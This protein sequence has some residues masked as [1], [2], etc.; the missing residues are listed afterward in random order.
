MVSSAVPQG[1]QRLVA[2]YLQQALPQRH[3]AVAAALSLMLME[4]VFQMLGHASDGGRV[5]APVAAMRA[6]LEADP[7]LD[8]V[9]ESAQDQ[10]SKRDLAAPH[11]ELMS[12]LD[13]V[14]P[15]QSHT[16]V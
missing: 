16:A 13:S 11:L 9:V 6:D 10:A 7:V 4:A 14:A 15:Q 2:M 8:P 5:A 12:T 1:A 3:D